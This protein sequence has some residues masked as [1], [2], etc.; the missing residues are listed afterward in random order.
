MGASGSARVWLLS[1]VSPSPSRFVTRREPD[2]FPL[3]LTVYANCVQ[4]PPRQE[5]PR[6]EGGLR[7]PGSEEVALLHGRR[8]RTG[9]AGQGRAHAEGHS[10]LS[11]RRAWAAT[12]CA[13][14]VEGHG[15]RTLADSQLGRNSRFGEPNFGR[16]NTA[17]SLKP[18]QS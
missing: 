11:R 9:T 2:C 8:R 17:S 16:H 10:A 15:D 18:D 7:V 3:T 4:P 13:R 12:G 14:G 6:I 5:G 1:F